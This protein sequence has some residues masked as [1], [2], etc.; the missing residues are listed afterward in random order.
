MN[1]PLRQINNLSCDDEKIFREACSKGRLKYIKLL[2]KIKPDI[3]ISIWDEMPFCNVCEYGHLHIAKWLLKKKVNINISVDDEAPFCFA[4][5][6][7]HLHIVKW[8]LKIKPDINIYADEHW[9]F[10]RTCK[11][12]H[13]NTAL[14]FANT[15][16]D[17]YCVKT[18]KQ[19]NITEWF[20]RKNIIVSKTKI[21]KD[22]D[23]CI[24]CRTYKSNIITSCNHQF[25]YECLNYL[26]RDSK[27]M[28]C[29]LCRNKNIKFF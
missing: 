22:I 10:I 16:P 27:N 14:F 1:S 18:D 25:C 12:G 19:N 29:P 9:A 13:T 2:L 24:I 28:L 20:V 7:G 26:Y 23:D 6:N 21:I 15:Y 8:L 4:A 17:L 11:N 3:N 5:M